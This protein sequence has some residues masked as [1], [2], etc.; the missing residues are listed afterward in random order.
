M[1]G[2]SLVPI[3][4]PNLGEGIREAIVVALLHP[5]GDSVAKNGPLVQ[6]ETSKAVTDIPASH[7]GILHEWSVGPG[8]VV[9]VGDCLGMI[10]AEG[11]GSSD[12]SVEPVA[13]PARPAAHEASNFLRNRNLPPRTKRLLEQHGLMP[14]ADQ[15]PRS[16]EKLLPEDVEVFLQTPCGAVRD[17]DATSRRLSSDE[18]LAIRRLEG[19]GAGPHPSMTIRVEWTALAANAKSKRIPTERRQRFSTIAIGWAVGQTMLRH[20]L[21]RSRFAQNATCVTSRAAHLGIAVAADGALPSI[22]SIAIEASTTWEAFYLAAEAAIEQATA[23]YQHG[24]PTTAVILTNMMPFGVHEGIP[25][26]VAPAIAVIAVGDVYLAPV[27]QGESVGYAGLF[28]MSMTFDHR[29]IGGVQAAQFLQAVREEIS[30]LAGK[31]S[32]GT[33]AAGD[34]IGTLDML[35]EVRRLL[36]LELGLNPELLP[37]DVPIGEMGID[38]IVVV[39]FAVLAEKLANSLERRFSVKAPVFESLPQMTLRQIADLIE[40]AP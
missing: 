12:K 17:T 33:P 32:L 34:L 14:V 29:L 27:R 7:T 9:K 25:S 28:N 1:N 11:G 10:R 13:I 39:E 35:N 26:L 8:D 40:H 5:P 16:G 4:V 24:A 22:A 37:A 31:R 19:S 20:P 6:I 3:L 15:I 30:D 23:T 21:F 38:S 18:L 2:S 36:A